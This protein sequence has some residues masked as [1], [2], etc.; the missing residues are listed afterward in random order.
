MPARFWADLTTEEF[1]GL[2]PET[3]IA[4][5]PVAAIEQHGPHLPLS[6]DTTIANGMIDEAI[7]RARS[8]VTLLVLPTQYLGKS[9]EHIRS[10]GTLT[11]SAE[12][13]IRVLTET[14]AAVARSGVRKLIFVSSHG[15]N[16]EVLGIAARTLR[17]EHAVLAV[18]AAWGRF[19]TPDGLL[20]AREAKV[21]IHAGD[22]ETS[23]MLHFAPDHV[24]R[25]ALANFT[26]ATIAMMEEFT[27]LRPTGHIAFSW[28]AQDLHPSGA[29]GD[30]RAASAEKGRAIAAYQVTGFLSLVEDVARFKL[31]RL[32]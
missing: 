25:D 19:G 21:G 7:A 14:G 9:D 16:V 30:A 17:I 12:T 13:M 15:G 29:I 32:A 1:R 8:D 27:H 5:L 6:T 2:D 22:L 4:V 18:V 28:I 24:R 10:P 3:T 20:D 31:D 26:P 11:L 23:L